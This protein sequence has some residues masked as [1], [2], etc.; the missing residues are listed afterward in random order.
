[1][2]SSQD[3]NPRREVSAT[4]KRMANWARPI[5]DRSPL[6]ATA[7]TKLSG[8]RNLQNIAGQTEVYLFTQLCPLSSE[9][10]WQNPTHS[11]PFISFALLSNVLRHRLSSFSGTATAVLTVSRAEAVREEGVSESE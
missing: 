10:A 2:K 11:S 9:R 3:T 1:V 6:E 5:F 7:L 8:S 4:R